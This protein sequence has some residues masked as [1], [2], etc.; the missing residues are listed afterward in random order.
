MCERENDRIVGAYMV[1]DSYKLR[2]NISQKVK[3]NDALRSYVSIP[4]RELVKGRY[5]EKDGK[6][7]IL[8]LSCYTFNSI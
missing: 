4:G 1:F 6:R 3:R 2:N 8:S 5:T 7:Y